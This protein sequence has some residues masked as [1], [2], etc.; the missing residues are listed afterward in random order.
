[1]HNLQEDWSLYLDDD[2][3]AEASLG[4][5]QEEVWRGNSQV[6]EAAHRDGRLSATRH[7]LMAIYRA[8]HG[9][10]P[11]EVGEA[12]FACDQVEALQGWLEPFVTD[13]PGALL[14]LVQC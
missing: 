1:M 5:R 2:I 12:I 11:D 4:A 13:S 14:A 10:V 3:R 7:A 8:R 6:H 9:E